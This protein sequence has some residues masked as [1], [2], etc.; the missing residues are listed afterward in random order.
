MILLD[1]CS[2]GVWGGVNFGKHA[3][4]E[5]ALL[6]IVCFLSFYDV[7]VTRLKKRGIDMYAYIAYIYAC[8]Y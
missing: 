6:Q 3:A 5:K 2:W 4:T 1:V 7:Y 8:L